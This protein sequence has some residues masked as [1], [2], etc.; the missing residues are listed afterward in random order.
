MTI[1]KKTNESLGVLT[2]EKEIAKA[3]ELMQSIKD[4]G[5]EGEENLPFSLLTK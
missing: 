3:N 4:D 2:D 5:V 1:L